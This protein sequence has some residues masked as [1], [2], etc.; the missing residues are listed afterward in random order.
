MRGGAGR[1]ARGFANRCRSQAFTGASSGRRSRRSNGCRDPG[2]PPPTKPEQ[3]LQA[4]AGTKPLEEIAEGTFFGY[5][6]LGRSYRH[7]YERAGPD[8][9]SRKGLPA[10]PA[11]RRARPGRI[12]RPQ[13]QHARHDRLS[14]PA[15][16]GHG[17]SASRFDARNA[18]RPGDFTAAP[19]KR[20]ILR[21]ERPPAACQ[22]AR[23]RDGGCLRCASEGDRPAQ[24][25]RDA[26][27]DRLTRTAHVRKRFPAAR[28]RDVGSM[29]NDA[30]AFGPETDRP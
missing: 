2:C 5:P 3:S 1:P 9:R 19:G 18:F 23:P 29:A 10:E 16:G 14:D 15:A 28:L 8:N 24:E 20:G 22:L 6:I 21:S 13:A 30:T 4:L 12:C 17:L 11:C 26:R 25:F 7:I 27:S